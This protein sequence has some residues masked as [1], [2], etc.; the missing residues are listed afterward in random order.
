[1]ST[2]FWPLVIACALLFGCATSQTSRVAK[3]PSVD[4]TGSWAGTFSWQY[5]VSPMTLT[6]RQTGADVTGEIVTERGGP[7]SGYTRQGSGPVSGTVSEDSVSL[8]F[9]G[10]AADLVVKGASM[11]GVSSHGSSWTLRR[12]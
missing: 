12:Q 2:F 8:T 7:S 10:G 6:L 3:P 11:S 4:V 1:M 9:S 5:G